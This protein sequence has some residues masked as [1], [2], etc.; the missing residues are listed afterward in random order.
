MLISDNYRTLNAELHRSSERFG[1]RGHKWAERVLA[2]ARAIGAG[3]LLDYGCGKGTMVAALAPQIPARG[4]DPAVAAFSAEPASADFVTCNDVLEHIEPELLDNVLADLHRLMRKGGLFVISTIRSDKA[5]A[6]GRNAHLIVRPAR[7]WLER[8][9]PWFHCEQVPATKPS[10]R[11]CAVLVRPRAEPIRR[12]RVPRDWDGETVVIVAPGTSLADTDLSALAGRRTVAIN[13]AFIAVPQAD[14]LLSGDHRF[15]RRK[16]DLARYRGPLIVAVDPKTFDDS[17]PDPRVEAMRRNAEAG[18]STDPACVAGAATSVAYA[19]NY[20][21]LRGGRRLVLVGLDGRPGPGGI[22]RLGSGE[23]EGL[24]PESA[25]KVRRRYAR[26]ADVL[27]TQLEPLAALGVD[28]VN[29]TPGS[30]FDLYRHM[31]LAEA[32]A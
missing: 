19:I 31:P 27:K 11:E 30:A 16:P 21:A 29:A 18:I 20:A 10:A 13:D 3:D 17:T 7:W 25:E 4:Y 12:H 22:R 28:V 15:F 1:A 2:R 9:F 14:V 6:D 23:I 26:Q 32:L 5:L 8:L 24:E